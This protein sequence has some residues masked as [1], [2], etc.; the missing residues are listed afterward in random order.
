VR[1]LPKNRARFGKQAATF[2]KFPVL[3]GLDVTLYAN[4]ECCLASSVAHPIG[5]VLW[6]A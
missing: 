3:L 1:A 5:T 2:G 4:G 6:C